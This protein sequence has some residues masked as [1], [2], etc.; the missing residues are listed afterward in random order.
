M[1]REIAW[2]GGASV[3]GEDWWPVPETLED[4]PDTDLRRNSMNS[5]FL[6]WWTA[7]IHEE[8]PAGDT[9]PA[10][11]RPGL[12]VHSTS[13]RRILAAKKLSAAIE[14]YATAHKHEGYVP[15]DE[16]LV[17]QVNQAALGYYNSIK[18]RPAPSGTDT[19]YA[20]YR[21]LCFTRGIQEGQTLEAIYE[22]IDGPQ[23]AVVVS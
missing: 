10:H 6:K 7:A 4:D 1:T 3:E 12:D 2:I 11:I 22:A 9:G 17:T 15:N 18:H 23:N 5:R 16:M 20:D 8:L 13:Y 19:N 14:E 21:E